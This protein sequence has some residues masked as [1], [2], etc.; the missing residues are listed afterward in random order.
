MLGINLKRLT[1]FFDICP[2]CVHYWPLPI[3]VM[4]MALSLA[5]GHK[6]SGKQ[7]LVDFIFSPTWELIRMKF[8]MVVKQFYLTY[9]Y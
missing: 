1:R 5:E 4:L 8:D 7:K 6:V 2:A 9:W 3:F